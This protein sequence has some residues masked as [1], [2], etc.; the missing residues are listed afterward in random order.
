M[1]LDLTAL[2]A[3]L[4][5]IRQS[6]LDE[7]KVELIVRRPAEDER[8]VLIEGHLDLEAGLVGDDWQRR[9][10]N[11]DGQ[12]TLMN[13]RAVALLS[14]IPGPD[15][16]VDAAAALAAVPPEDPLAAPSP[17]KRLAARAAQ[18]EVGIRC[19][20]WYLK[21]VVP[22]IE[23]ALDR[24]TGG[25]LTALPITPVVFLH[26]R[27]APQASYHRRRMAR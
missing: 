25:R 7:G 24:W 10:G 18:T 15:V 20:G 21:Q 9:G 8:E 19:A 22:R 5:E 27:G 17:V 11:L 3:G 4:D 26:T 13:V 14:L 2:E 23:P 16:T 6:P 12:V 1:H